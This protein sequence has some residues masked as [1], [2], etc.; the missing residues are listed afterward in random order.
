MVSYISASL[1]Y[2]C[3]SRYAFQTERGEQGTPHLQ[4]IFHAKNQIAFSTVKG[5]N[6]R[7]HLEPT[8]D[9]TQSVQYC[10]KPEGR[11]GPVYI[12]GFTARSPEDLRLLT[13]DQLFNWQREL[14][15]ELH[16][17]PNKRRVVWYFDPDGGAGKTELCRYLLHHNPQTLFVST[18]SAKDILY[19]VIKNREDPRTILVNLTRSAEGTF[20]YGAIEAIKDGLVFS[21]KYEGGFRMFPHPH[22]VIFANWHPDITQ[23]TEDRWDIRMLR[24]NAILLR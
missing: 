2:P 5:W 19:Q 1:A 18:A 16:E 8:R 7:L 10:T 13:E 12:R 11:C 9:I 4:G 15:A 20:A 3:F 14:V 22:I 24:N 6:T 23:L 21:G 17:Q